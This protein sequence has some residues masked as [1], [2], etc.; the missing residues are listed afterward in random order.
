MCDKELENTGG[1]PHRT[2]VG[3]FCIKFYCVQSVTDL[4]VMTNICGNFQVTR[5]R[6]FCRMFSWVECVTGKCGQHKQIPIFSAC[7]TVTGEHG[8]VKS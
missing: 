8:S 7:V 5:L 2:D 4:K 3:H 6:N 1:N